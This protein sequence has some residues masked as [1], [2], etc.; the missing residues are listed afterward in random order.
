MHAA[1][2]LIK[3]HH[4]GFLSISSSC[5]AKTRQI[6]GFEMREIQ[7]PDAASNARVKQL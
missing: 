6:H 2:V 4:D 3:R 7:V 5:T 1:I